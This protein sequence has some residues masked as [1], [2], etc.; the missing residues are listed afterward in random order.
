MRN[1]D[2]SACHCR[3]LSWSD[4]GGRTWENRRFAH[5]LPDPTCQGSTIAVGSELFFSNA[6][7][8]SQRVNGTIH[9]SVDG[10]ETWSL[11]TTVDEGTYSYSALSYLGGGIIGVLWESM[12]GGTMTIRFTSKNI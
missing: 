8:P 3:I 12:P 4:D 1:E 7:N 2:P 5:E 9:T 6:D 11:L 10:G